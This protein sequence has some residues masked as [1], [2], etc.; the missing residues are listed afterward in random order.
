MASHFLCRSS[1]VLIMRHKPADD[2]CSRSIVPGVRESHSNLLR[3]KF[4]VRISRATPPYIATNCDARRT[5]RNR[6]ESTYFRRWRGIEK[7]QPLA[8]IATWRLRE[9]RDFVIEG[10]RKFIL[11]TGTHLLRAS[12]GRSTERPTD[13]PTIRP[14]S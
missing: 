2:T 6:T 3:K 5:P 1:H 9:R 14:S 11:G 7:I 13:R 10:I 4:G 8:V 12:L